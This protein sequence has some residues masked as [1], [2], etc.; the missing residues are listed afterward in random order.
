VNFACSLLASSVVTERVVKHLFSLSG[1]LLLWVLAAPFPVSVHAEAPS[2]GEYLLGPGDIIHITVFNNPELTTDARVSETGSITFP[3]IGSVQV[4]GLSLSKAQDAIA[5]R[6]DQGHYVTKAQINI[7]PTLIVGS[8]VTVVGHVNRPGRYPLQTTLTHIS[9]ALALAGGADPLGADTIVLIQHRSDGTEVRNPV[10]MNDLFA[11]GVGH[12]QLVQ[13]GDTIY[14]PRQSEFYVYGE[15]EHPGAFRLE[16]HMTLMQGLALGGFV[17][18]RGSERRTQ[19][20]RQDDSGKMQEV[21]LN[22]TDM[23]LPNDTIYV[24]SRIF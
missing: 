2:A 23:L 18:E 20:F 19:I 22:L 24:R 4:V 17:N 3:L 21:A 6:L 16:P 10:D 13:G 12:D 14:V 11:R 15:V 5:V 1:A 8:Q 7:L 9:D